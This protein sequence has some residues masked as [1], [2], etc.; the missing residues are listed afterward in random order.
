MK[1]AHQLFHF[2]YSSFVALTPS[3]WLASFSAISVFQECVAS[4][5]IIE[6]LQEYFNSSSCNNQ[7]KNINFSAKI[8]CTEQYYM[9]ASFTENAQRHLAA[10]NT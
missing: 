2:F 3:S 9:C 5:Q 7:E 8:L 6:E 10:L 1:A 4:P